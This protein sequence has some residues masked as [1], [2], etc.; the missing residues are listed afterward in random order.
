MVGGASSTKGRSDEEQAATVTMGTT[1]APSAA[2]MAL[3]RA[4]A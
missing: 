2:A 4:R 3:D 1:K